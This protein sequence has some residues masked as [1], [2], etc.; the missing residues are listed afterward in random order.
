MVDAQTSDHSF[1]QELKNE[2][3]GRVED[4]RILHANGR[5]FVDVKEPPVV[6]FIRRDP[7][8]GEPIYLVAE[9]LVQ[10]IKALCIS[11]CSVQNG[12]IFT[13]EGLDRVTLRH[14]ACQPPP[15]DLFFPIAFFDS[16]R[17]QIV[18]SGQISKSRQDAL[19]L[20]HRRI[21]H[22]YPANQ[23]IQTKNEDHDRVFRI[24]GKPVIAVSNYKPPFVVCNADFLVLHHGAILLSQNG[25]QNFTLQLGLD[26]MPIDIEERRIAG[27]RSVFQ[28]IQP[29][30]VP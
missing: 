23:L 26:R 13:Y 6:D 21:I 29:P 11:L 5:E 1:S 18:P 28:N 25:Q 14:N 8:M 9:E 3:V 24:N 15:D 20:Q 12:D 22:S 2:L 27:P 7:P 16:R 10:Q 30:G 4:D 17:I 19:K